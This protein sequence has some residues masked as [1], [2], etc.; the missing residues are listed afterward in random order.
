MY[1]LEKPKEFVKKG[2]VAL[3][4]VDPDKLGIS[5]KSV[6]K[7][8]GVN[9]AGVEKLLVT[10]HDSVEKLGREQFEIS[11]RLLPVNREKGSFRVLDFLYTKS[12][13]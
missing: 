5:E 8:N 6:G 13:Q 7:V 4:Q 10:I 3:Y 1:Y 11:F 12:V 2:E 9:W